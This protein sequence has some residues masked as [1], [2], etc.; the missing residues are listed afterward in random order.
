MDD[1]Y[2]EHILDLSR[3]PRQ[4]GRL[5]TPTCTV[6]EHNPSCGDAIEIDLLLQSDPVAQNSTILDLRWRGQGCAIS[7]AAASALSQL[8]KGK[9]KTEISQWNLKFVLQNLGLP[10][11][12]PARHKCALLFLGTLQKALDE[13]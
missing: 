3:H 11:L 13:H 12:T 7:Q 5:P 10:E 9:T 1:L 2:Q 8:A 6:H 4:Y